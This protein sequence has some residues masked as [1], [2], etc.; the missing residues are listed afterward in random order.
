MAARQTGKDYHS[1][2]SKSE[3]EKALARKSALR[4]RL[5]K[6][7][8]L[9]K[10]RGVEVPF[11]AY[12]E[13]AVLGAAITHPRGF[14]IMFESLN[15]D[16]LRYFYFEKH[17]ELYV[18]LLHLHK[19]NKKI[20]I[21]SVIEQLIAQ[22]DFQ[23]QDDHDYLMDIVFNM[24]S[25]AHVQTHVDNV[26]S[27]FILREMIW[28]CKTI[29]DQCLVPSATGKETLEEAEAAL[30][31]LSS[32]SVRTDFVSLED[33]ILTVVEDLKI[34]SATKGS[35]RGVTS[36]FGQLDAVTNGWQPGE[37]IILAA[38]PSVGK[39]AMAL[40]F[41]LAAARN[42]PTRTA[43]G[44]FSLEMT[45][46]QLMMRMMSMMGRY[47]LKQ[48][49]QA[50]LSENDIQ[51][52]VQ[53]EVAELSK[54]PILFDDTASISILELR[55]KARRM[56]SENQVGLVIIDYLQLIQAHDMRNVHNREQEIS[57]ISRELKGLAKELSIPVIALAQL[58]REV[59]KRSTSSVAAEPR[60]SDL[61]ESGA[62]E[63]DADLVMLLYRDDPQKANMAFMDG[64]IP[65]SP[66]TQAEPLSHLKLAKHRNGELGLFDFRFHGKYQTF[67]PYVDDYFS[68][69]P[70]SP[71]REDHRSGDTQPN[72]KTAFPNTRHNYPANPDEG[73]F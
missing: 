23:G 31:E 39:T 9:A 58:S 25:L 13:R 16:D 26:K 67:E 47:A 44:F 43:V 27:K 33:Q 7:E 19:Q 51:S 70:S 40:N 46:M 71:L 41:A 54:C 64:G 56:V 60:L 4:E 21:S 29:T 17:Q 62:I 63:Q 48:F 1:K 55:S 72:V 22:Q 34:R 30:F 11:A 57:K 6:I 10:A 49:T 18:A 42:K 8:E 59:E 15:R 28:S 2:S 24:S 35:L 37:L 50:K 3:A 66:S 38:R 68:P 20:D 32:L 45:G 69:T 36:G 14:D 65:A 12:S 52:I 5:D 61:R 53:K 73:P